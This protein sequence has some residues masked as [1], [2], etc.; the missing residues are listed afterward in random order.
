MSS[1]AEVPFI[2][3]SA[4]QFFQHYNHI[5]HTEAEKE[6]ADYKRY[7]ESHSVEEIEAANKARKTL[8]SKLKDRPSEV[9]KWK[10]IRDER[11][12]KRPMTSF[13][14]FCTSRHA[15]GD[16]KHLR[17]SEA[18]KLLGQEWKAL[19]EGEKQVCHVFYP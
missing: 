1:S 16:F 4:D 5:A 17:A 9:K 15:S 12:V 18:A 19:S 11:S 3:R 6:Q 10:P 8:R 14:H 13:A 2:C 7:V